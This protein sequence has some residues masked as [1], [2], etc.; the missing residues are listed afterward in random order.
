MSFSNSSVDSSPM[1][2]CKITKN[3]NHL[4]FEKYKWDK[5]L[6]IKPKICQFMLWQKHTRTQINYF[7]NSSDVWLKWTKDIKML[8]EAAN[9]FIVLQL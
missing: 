1:L 6:N 5:L 3:F 9:F 4:Y 2:Q 8:V 7:L